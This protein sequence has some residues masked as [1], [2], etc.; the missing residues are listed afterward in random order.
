MN[1]FTIEQLRALVAFGAVIGSCAEI[2]LGEVTVGYPADLTNPESNGS[3]EVYNP[4]TGECV[5]V[6]C[7]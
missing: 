6:P 7:Y 3:R 4:D 5:L 2:I 1:K